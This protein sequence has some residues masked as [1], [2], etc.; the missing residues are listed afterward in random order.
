MQTREVLGQSG[1]LSTSEKIRNM[2]EHDKHAKRAVWAELTISIDNIDLYFSLPE[3]LDYVCEIFETVPFP[4]ALTL[5]NKDP[6]EFRL[7]TH[8]LSR[9][10]KKVKD[11]KYRERFIKYVN[12]APKELRDFR[13]FYES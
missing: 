10:P 7:N 2:F 12:S 6:N 11:K 3:E 4:T 5:A 13:S 8:W 1:F 9:L